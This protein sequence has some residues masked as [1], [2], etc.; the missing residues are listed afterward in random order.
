MK[1]IEIDDEVFAYLQS[2]A[3]AYVENP[4]LTLRRILGIEKGPIKRLA[5]VRTLPMA[6]SPKLA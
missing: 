4:N 6:R 5:L 1:T 2:K 3:I